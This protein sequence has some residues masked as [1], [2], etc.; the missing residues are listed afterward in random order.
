MEYQLN[1]I[2]ESY[3][4]GFSMGEGCF[5][6]KICNRRKGRQPRLF[7]SIC[8]VFTIVQSEVDL[9]VLTFTQKVLGFGSLHKARYTEENRRATY[10]LVISGLKRCKKVVELFDKYPL[11]GQKRKDYEMWKEAI[12]RIENGEHLSVDGFLKLTQLRDN[13]N[14]QGL[15]GKCNSRYRDT[16]F[17][18]NF[19]EKHL[20]KTLSASPKHYGS[21]HNVD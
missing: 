9:G 4:V 3:V 14:L 2:L 17:F 8:P 5:H 1:H 18:R 20:S 10:I 16:A 12:L 15:T 6:I 11:F 21:R 7:Y 13:M 19:F